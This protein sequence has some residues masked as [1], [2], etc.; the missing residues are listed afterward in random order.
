MPNANDFCVELCFHSQSLIN[1]VYFTSTLKKIA[2]F[3]LNQPSPPPP[4]LSQLWI[5]EFLGVQKV[6]DIKVNQMSFAPST[7]VGNFP[8]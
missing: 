8:K 1:M 5:F 2:C 4:P 6:A 7:S 3:A